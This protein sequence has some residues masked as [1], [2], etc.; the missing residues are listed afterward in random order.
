VIEE[1]STGLGMDFGWCVRWE[2]TDQYI[3]LGSEN[4]IIPDWF[5]NS[6]AFYIK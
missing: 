5:K 1:P 2:V 6:P 4:G 3:N